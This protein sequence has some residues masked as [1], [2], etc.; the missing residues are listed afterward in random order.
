MSLILWHEVDQTDEEYSMQ[1]VCGHALVE[2]S[3][4][5]LCTGQSDS[6]NG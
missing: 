2:P 6:Y 5:W 1:E 4:N 3:Q